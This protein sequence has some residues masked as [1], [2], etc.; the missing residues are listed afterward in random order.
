MNILDQTLKE[1]KR[2][3]KDKEILSKCFKCGSKDVI[4]NTYMRGSRMAGRIECNKCGAIT[5]F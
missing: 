1:Q 3:K 5:M 4:D 2:K